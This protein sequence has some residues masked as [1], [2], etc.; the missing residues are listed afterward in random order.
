MRRVLVLVLLLA[1]LPTSAGAVGTGCEIKIPR[2]GARAM[3]YRYDAIDQP[4]ARFYPAEIYGDLSEVDPTSTGD[5]YLNAGAMLLG[6]WSQL[7]MQDVQPRGVYTSTL[8]PP[9]EVELPVGGAIPGAGEPDRYPYQ[10]YSFDP[11][12]RGQELLL[13]WYEVSGR[14]INYPPGF[15]ASISW[16]F[17]I[18]GG[19]TP[20]AISEDITHLD[21]RSFPGNQ[22]MTPVAGVSD[23]MDLQFT[24]DDDLVVGAIQ[25]GTFT[26][27]RHVTRTND[28]CTDRFFY[29]TPSQEMKEE[30]AGI[31]AFIDGPGEFALR[32]WYRCLTPNLNGTIVS[33]DVPR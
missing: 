30:R 26:D 28:T 20:I 3:L 5:G 16:D 32:Y 4:Q 9:T 1:A 13:V 22:T 19:C 31:G 33:M 12:P 29:D 7:V 15:D 23:W 6:R 17:R 24:R 21:H 2:D 27:P 10:T 14:R 18:P 8:T 25:H 11:Y